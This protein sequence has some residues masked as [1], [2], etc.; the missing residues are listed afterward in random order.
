M[1]TFCVMA[2][3]EIVVAQNWGNHPDGFKD[4]W[5]RYAHPILGLSMIWGLGCIPL[6]IFNI[7][8]GERRIVLVRL[9]AFLLMFVAAMFLGTM[10]QGRLSAHTL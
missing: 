2:L 3:S 9:M 7:V 6:L 8:V 4:L 5:L 10:F 1:L